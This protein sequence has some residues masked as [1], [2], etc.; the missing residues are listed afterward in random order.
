MVK[1]A[2]FDVRQDEIPHFNKYEHLYQLSIDRFEAPLRLDNMDLVR[3]CQ[4]ISVLGQSEIN[5]DILVALVAK[6][7]RQV[8]TRTVGTNHIDLAAAG[9]WGIRVTNASYPPDG[10]AEFT[11]MLLLLVL[12]K[13]KQAMYRANVNDY[14][15]E[16]LEGRELKECT[17]GIIGTGAIGTA[18]IKL[19]KGFGCQVFAYVRD[20]RLKPELE[21]YAEA[22]DLDFIYRTCDIISLHIPVTETSRHFID[23]KAINAMKEGVILINSSRGGLMDVHALMEGIESSKIGGLAMDVFENEAEIY[24]RDRRLEIISNREM[25]YL[26][27]FPNVVMTQHMAFYTARDIEYMVRTGLESFLSPLVFSTYGLNGS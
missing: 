15:L 24:H 9:K 6:G 21:G 5:E 11:V 18:V 4:G 20:G 19:L 25:A 26:R 22:R 12:R 16:G 13:Y 3:D 8:N 23:K 7:I 1:I 27:Q 17:V 14:S 2:A 10:V